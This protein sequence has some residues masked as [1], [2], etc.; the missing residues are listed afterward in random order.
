M[1]GG[2]VLG[3][4]GSGEARRLILPT[5]SAYPCFANPQPLCARINTFLAAG[6]GGLSQT[7]LRRLHTDEERGRPRAMLTRLG[8]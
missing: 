1:Y 2:S 3:G 7:E 8:S 4:W 5:H 6:P